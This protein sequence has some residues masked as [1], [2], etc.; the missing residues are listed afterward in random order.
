[1]FGPCSALFEGGTMSLV[2]APFVQPSDRPQQDF[3]FEKLH[4]APPP[5]GTVPTIP[6]PPPPTNPPQVLTDSWGVSH[7]R[8]GCSP[9]PPP[10][11]SHI[12]SPPDTPKVPEYV[13]AIKP[14]R[15]WL[16]RTLSFPFCLGSLALLFCPVCLADYLPVM[17]TFY[18]RVG[19]QPSVGT[20]LT[21][22]TSITFALVHSLVLS[23]C[24][25]L[26]RWLALEKGH[27][28]FFAFRFTSCYS[29]HQWNASVQHWLSDA[30]SAPRTEIHL[31]CCLCLPRICISLF[32][33]YQCENPQCFCVPASIPECNHMR[34]ALW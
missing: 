21:V 27:T 26:L 34:R 28:A 7:I 12:T 5:L 29:S 16:P 9:P 31:P 33:V 3:D 30:G 6:P 10:R 14:T 32:P 17:A 4:E 19:L 1:M 25:V 11:G 2:L 23:D 13:A 24:F 15:L 22:Y 20:V 8:T 18:W